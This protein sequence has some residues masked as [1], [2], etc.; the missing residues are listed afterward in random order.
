LLVDDHPR[1]ELVRRE[2]TTPFGDDLDPMAE[3]NGN[4]GVD[5]VQ[6]L[7]RKRPVEL[8]GDVRPVS[9]P[10]RRQLVD[11]RLAVLALFG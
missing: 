9:G 6:R 10:P 3:S 7:L 1:D 4:T 2:Q 8:I 5:L 11:R